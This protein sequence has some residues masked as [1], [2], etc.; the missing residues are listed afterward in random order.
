MKKIKSRIFIKSIVLLFS[1]AYLL[2]ALGSV[3]FTPVGLN[4]CPNSAIS[5]G[6][7]HR[8]NSVDYNEHNVTFYCFA[9]KFYLDENQLNPVKL[10][11]LL[12]ITLFG[13]LLFE[14][15][16][17]FSPLSIR[18]FYNKQPCYLSFRTFRI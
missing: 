10:V 14:T 2:Y 17:T 12:L 3:F 11:A 6:F 7:A 9:D 5:T 13:F 18:L 15:R 16:R 4:L 8:R 1:A